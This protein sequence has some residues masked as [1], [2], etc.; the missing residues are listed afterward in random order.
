[1]TTLNIKSATRVSRL[2]DMWIGRT[3][4]AHFGRVLTAFGPA[5]LILATAGVIMASIL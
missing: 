2:S 4:Q 1:M 3:G 5:L